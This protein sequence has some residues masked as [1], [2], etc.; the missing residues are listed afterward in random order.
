MQVLVF[1]NS[2]RRQVEPVVRG[3]L[4]AEPD[5]EGL[6]LTVVRLLQG[7]TVNAAGVRDPT[8]A[9]SLCARAED[10]LRQSDI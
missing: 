1:P 6:V 3:A 10:A 2:R 8:R 4:S 7:W 5:T 9:R